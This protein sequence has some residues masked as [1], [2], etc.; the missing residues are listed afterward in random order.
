MA[1]PYT[2]VENLARAALGDFGVRDSNGDIVPNSQDYASEDIV[3]VITLALLRFEDY[4]GD[5]ADITPTIANDNDLGSISYYVALTLVLPAGPFTLESPNMRYILRE[6]HELLSSLLGNMQ[7][8]LGL[9]AVV[10]AMWGAWD[11]LYN[12][13]ELVANRQVAAI[14]SYPTS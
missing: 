12:Q 14:G 2:T 8:F 10:P 1:T 6:N 5:G 4:S 13:P 7:Y 9:G 11:Q 3:K